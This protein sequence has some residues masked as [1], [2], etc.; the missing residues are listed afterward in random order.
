M[1]THCSVIFGKE[2]AVSPQQQKY[3]YQIITALVNVCLK[4][5]LKFPWSFFLIT[6]ILL[7][8]SPVLCLISWNFTMTHPALIFT[9]N[10]L[11]LLIFYHL[12]SCIKG[13][14]TPECFFRGWASWV[15]V[16]KHNFT[17][18]CSFL[19]GVRSRV[20]LTQSNSG[21][22]QTSRK[23]PQYCIHCHHTGRFGWSQ[24]FLYLYLDSVILGTLGT[25]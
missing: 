18:R 6:H 11:S 2:V 7:C 1:V 20:S 19:W 24:T 13:T 15:T 16:Q 14:T 25:F 22:S 8:I 17:A 3:S 4:T 23:P 12:H 5:P 9:S 21:R 10:D